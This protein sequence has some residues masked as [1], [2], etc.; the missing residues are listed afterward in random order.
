LRRI[1]GAGDE[2]EPGAGAIGGSTLISELA[3]DDAQVE[4]LVLMF[5]MV[6]IA[7]LAS[8]FNPLIL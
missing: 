7:P 1:L 6:P 3:L 5:L 2:E 8:F 4:L